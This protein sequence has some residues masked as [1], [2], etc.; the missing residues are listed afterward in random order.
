VTG[1]GGSIG[2]ELCRQISPLMPSRLILV[3]QGENSIF[4]IEQELIREF[5]HMPISMIADIKDRT[6][7]EDIFRTER[8]TVVFHAAAHKH[9]PLMEANP[10]EAVKNNVL[11]TRNVAE[12][13]A[14]YGVKKFIYVSTD[15]AVNPTSVMGATKRIGEMIIQSLS[16][17]T[18]TEFAAVRFGNVLGSR[19][20]VIPTMRRQIA[21]GGPVTVT[22]P[23][24]TRYFMTIPEAV[25]LILQAGMIGGKG[26]VF[27]LDMGEPVRI[28]DLARDLI[29]LSGL[30]PAVDI[31]IV[32]TGARPGEK[33]D[34]ELLYNEENAQRTS[35]EKIFVS[36]K[37]GIDPEHV[38]RDVDR[39]I[40][41]ARKSELPPETLRS[42]ILRVAKDGVPMPSPSA[43]FAL[44]AGK[45]TAF[46]STATGANGITNGA[47]DP[48]VRRGVSGS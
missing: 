26:E 30:R 35:H 6:R 27:V 9:V 13:S 37:N 10:Q 46:D 45:A 41:L 17:T 16:K 32:F 28:V 39:L 18:R 25:Q 21:R 4:E 12:L 1:A 33:I 34:E 48:T 2:S 31:D 38:I 40:T 23:R 15:K 5:G 29:V 36:K 19:G 47:V 43:A 14:E 24:M 11:G 20:S 3:G 8:P 42:E 44:S 22:D 7:M